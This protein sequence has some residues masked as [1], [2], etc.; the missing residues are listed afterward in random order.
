MFDRLTI[1]YL[2]SLRAI[3]LIVHVHP[4]IWRVSWGLLTANCWLWVILLLESRG[5][6]EIG[7]K[8]SRLIGIGARSE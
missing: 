4:L 7:P 6:I 5:V 2:I 1:A 3:S 8:M